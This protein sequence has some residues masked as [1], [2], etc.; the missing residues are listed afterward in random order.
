MNHWNKSF[1]RSLSLVALYFSASITCGT[2]PQGRGS[3]RIPFEVTNNL[4]VLQGSI[5]NSKPLFLLL[6]TGASGSVI[7]ESRAKELG[8]NLEGQTK[9]ATGNGPVEASFVRGVT[10]D[11]SGIEFPNLTLT[12]IRLSGLEAGFGRPVDGILGYE[13]F[14]RFVV[15]IDYIS[16]IVTLH[17]PKSYKYSGSGQPIPLIIKDNRPFVRGKIMQVGAK[18]AEGNFEFDIGQVGAITLGESFTSEHELLK[19]TR[20]TL[21]TNTGSIL[22]GRTNAQIGR[23]QK[24]QLGR[25]IIQNAFTTFVSGNSGEEDTT[26][27]AGLIGAEILRRFK[28]T[29]DYS[30]KQVV[31]EPNKHF[32]EPYEFDMSGMSLTS[33]EDFKTFKVR[34]LVENSPAKEAGLRVGDIITAVNGKLTAV[35]TLEQIRRMFRQEGRR[36][37]LNIKRGESVL[38]LR[39]KTRRLI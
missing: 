20:K 3:Y 15:E 35:L 30:R 8:L 17:D 26:D 4:V 27:Y 39:I 10:L 2:V 12:S 9:A 33:G 23:I 19:F 7:N 18:A 6:D 1:P 21:Q 16:K 5:N 32:S 37:S 36:Y 29:I 13:I 31:L 34:T 24:L 22:A 28:V 14:N 38:P 11:V 25:F